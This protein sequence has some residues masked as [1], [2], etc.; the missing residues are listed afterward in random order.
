MKRM[1]DPA[2]DALVNRGY[3]HETLSNYI[4]NS[5]LIYAEARRA[6]E[7]EERLIDFLEATLSAIDDSVGGG[8]YAGSIFFYKE[9][10]RLL[11]ELKGEVEGK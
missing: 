7:N 10:K 2:F 5:R 9:V 11:A 4:A 1:D 6:R 8:N 3:G